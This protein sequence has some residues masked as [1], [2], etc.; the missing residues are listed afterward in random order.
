MSKKI[1]ELN[2]NNKKTTDE[3]IE[4]LLRM[5]QSLDRLNTINQKKKNENQRNNSQR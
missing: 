5:Q 2:Q 4:S 3:K 1:D